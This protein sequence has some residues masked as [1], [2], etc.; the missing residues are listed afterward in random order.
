MQHSAINQKINPAFLIASTILLIGVV[1]IL[2][3][4]GEPIRDFGNYYYASKL[5]AD[6]KF[7]N[8]IYNNIGHFN[9]LV[10]DYGEEQYFLN[11]IPVPPFSLFFYLPFTLFKSAIAKT[12]FNLFGLLF[13][14]F[15]VKR[16]MEQ[17]NVA[18]RI[19]WFLPFFSL[20][21]LYINI[22]Q[23]QSYLLITALI[24]ETF[25]AAQSKQNRLA[26]FYLSICILLKIFPAFLLLYF[27]LKKNYKL[28]LWIFI[29]LIGTT[30]LIL[31]LL[32]WPLIH[33]YF[34]EIMPRLFSNDVIG[35]YHT[36]NQSLYSLLLNI[37][38]F[39][40][41]NNPSPILE[42]PSMVPI[43]ESFM[44]A[45]FL[46]LFIKMRHKSDVLLYGLN[47]LLLTL[48]SRYNPSYSLFMIIPFFMAVSQKSI[49][50]YKQLFI[51]AVLTLALYCSF[52]NVQNNTLI[53][54]YLRIL[55]LCCCYIIFLSHFTLVPSMATFVVLFVSLSFIRYFTFSIKPIQYFALQNTQGILIDT[56]LNGDSLAFT[57]TMGDRIIKESFYLTGN[58]KRSSR[59]SIVDNQ[60]VYNGKMLTQT[61]DNKLQAYLFKNDSIV[62]VSDLNQGIRFYKLRKIA[63]SE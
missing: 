5:L 6:E 18:N 37:F 33:Q 22:A 25:I 43:I 14:C 46:S 12:L 19:T 23:G 17:F 45:Y 39:D 2:K 54:K 63:I 44:A 48:V 49:P 4:F 55:L 10:K 9:A 40:E 27:I 8:A 57:S 62:I 32:G 24:I 53:L 35:A 38:T 29:Y 50:A 15:S 34:F 7:T 31:L 41:L 1:I 47:S 30:T 36:S 20:V 16:F 58:L 51:I 42:L 28:L 13:F 21:P 61:S 11:Y 26:A 56:E 60:V 52:G 59:L 3:T